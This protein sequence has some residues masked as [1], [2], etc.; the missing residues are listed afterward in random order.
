[1][2]RSILICLPD[3]DFDPTE[4]ATPWHR[5]REAGFRVT[6]ATEHG[7]PG[8][9][10]PLLL[11]DVL[12]GKLGALP[13][14]LARYERMIQTSEFTAPLQWADVD[15]TRFDALLLPG[16]HA[17]G[18]R[19]YLESQALRRVVL[20]FWHPAKLVAAICHGVVVLARTVDPQTGQS[21]LHNRRCTALL[22]SLELS[23]WAATAWKLGDYY[24]TYPEW[25]EHEVTRMLADRKQ[26]ARGRAAWLPFVVKDANLVT[27][28]WP[29]D[30]ELFAA[31]LVQALAELGPRDS[32]N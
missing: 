2:P 31:E 17:K 4:V 29:K 20:A 23:G 22:K 25:V 14:A 18:M 8:A 32:T 19:Q 27:A 6:F 15:A 12:F 3:R 28:R 10:D 30:A 11:T 24:R 13:D 26:F 9:A 21:V 7:A 1:M 5:L 16:G